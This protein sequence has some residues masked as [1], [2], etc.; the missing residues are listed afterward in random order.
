M[1]ADL[2]WFHPA[3]SHPLQSPAM[4]EPAQPL[5]P[6]HRLNDRYR[7]IKVIGQ[8][9]M[10]IVWRAEDGLL[11]RQVA[12]KV[13][14]EQY[15]RDPEF[16]ARFRSEARSAAALNDP[17]VVAVHD[18]GQDGGWHYLVME[19][20]PGEDLKQLIR[21]EAPLEPSRVVRIATDIARAVG[22]A[23]AIGLVH[24]DIKPQNVLVT[25]DGRM[26][27]TD[28]GIA[29]AVS[30]AGMTAPGIVLGTVH[31]L[32]PEQAGG[33]P[34]TP[35]SDVY[36][37]GV[38]IY[39]M[40]TGKVPFAA[41]SGVGVAM[42]ILHEEPEPIELA[43]PGVPPALAQIL[44]RAMAREPGDRYPNASSM[45]EALAGYTEWSSDATM[46][47]F[48][49]SSLGAS[50]SPA[51]IP[52]AK[53]AMPDLLGQSAAP[54]GEILDR[55]GFLLGLLA[56]V[57]L[58]GLVPLW[59]GLAARLGAPGAAGAGLGQILGGVPTADPDV[60]AEPS[61][62]PTRAML[63]VPQ[64]EGELEADAR[65][66]LEKKGFGISVEY[67]P[68]ATVPNDR[69]IRQVPP[70]GSIEPS[71]KV[72]K[73]L[74][75]GDAQLTVPSLGG[76]LASVRAQ[77][78]GLGLQTRVRYEWTGGGSPSEGQ[79]IAIDPEPGTRVPYGYPIDLTV[80]GG[81]WRVV[82]VYFE[83]NLFLN[84]VTIG[85]AALTAGE[86]LL[87]TPAWEA[88]GPVGGDYLLRAELWASDGSVVARA[89]SAPLG[90]AGW[91]E[92]SK[93]EAGAIDLPVPPELAAGVYALYL[94]VVPAA[95]P[96]SS[97]G[98][99]QNAGLLRLS[100]NRVQLFGGVQVF[101]GQPQA[102]E[103]E[104]GGDAGD[105]SEDAGG[106]GGGDGEG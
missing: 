72:I 96:D 60:T 106:D 42:K 19:Y 2:A 6:D 5:L 56:L 89:E 74:V 57:A 22:Q 26:K 24:R 98:L 69:V 50:S 54:G 25:P 10:A 94:E 41:D 75:S 58:V 90:S 65:K 20:V 71:G 34:A 102:G 99:R 83:D 43:N 11:E 79:V 14:R 82:S 76:S 39:E 92:G 27:V 31:Y 81:P 95:A 91:A 86:H 29:R 35:A 49:P 23:H 18:V 68:D 9:G 70:G 1:V 45:A 28:F 51:Q 63:E 47:D 66:M 53:P 55:T 104:D 7:L 37:L 85:R 100:G 93:S 67:E 88:V 62:E 33:K 97:L 13:L 17:G 64:V 4:T 73:L 52:P 38:V 61:A 87:M 84:G 40:L 8:G 103:G 21:D 77:F 32:A 44:R 16:L 59:G 30:E 78:D 12:V 3:S 48:R 105:G 15:A 46:V 80:D 36:A 101:A